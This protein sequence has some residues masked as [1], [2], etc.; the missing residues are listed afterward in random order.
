MIKF[1]GIL[2]VFTML[3]FGHIPIKKEMTKV[4]TKNCMSIYNIYRHTFHFELKASS[5]Q[6]D[7]N[8][9]SQERITECRE[10]ERNV[11]AGE[12]EVMTPGVRMWM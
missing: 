1:T 9:T 2:Y 7:N 10:N 8:F 6:K 12:W 11:V 4:L 5:V 3:V